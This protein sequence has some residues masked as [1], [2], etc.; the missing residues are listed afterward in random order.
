MEIMRRKTEKANYAFAPTKGCPQL[1][2]NWKLPPPINTSVFFTLWRQI[3]KVR[4]PVHFQVRAVSPTGSK[5]GGEKALNYVAL[6]TDLSRFPPWSCNHERRGYNPD[7]PE[8]DVLWGRHTAI[9]C[10]PMLMARR[11]AVELGMICQ[12]VCKLW[13]IDSRDVCPAH[14]PWEI[15]NTHETIQWT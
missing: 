1:F 4:E 9:L 6:L 5:N 2:L 7:V 13:F 3:K 10:R 15:S 11:D 8:T 12:V 14:I